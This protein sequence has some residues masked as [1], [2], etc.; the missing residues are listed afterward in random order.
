MQVTTQRLAA[1]LAVA[2]AVIHVIEAPEYIEQTPYLGIGF[3]IGALALI[4]GAVLLW[5]R[6]RAGSGPGWLLAVLVSAGMFVGGILSRTTGLPGFHEEEW[7]PA[8]LVSLLL[9]AGVMVTWLV[10]QRSTASTPRA[11]AEPIR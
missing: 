3:V 4:V 1:A 9:E 7:E 5:R 6:R 10:A 8:L 2:V 11:H